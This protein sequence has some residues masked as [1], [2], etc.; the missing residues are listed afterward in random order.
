MK[1][2]VATRNNKKMKNSHNKKKSL[3]KFWGEK[4]KKK[5][6]VKIWK[7]L[8]NLQGGGIELLTFA[9]MGEGGVK[10][11]QNRAYVI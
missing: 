5:R 10:N 9:Y 8:R 3:G 11:G 1:T 2:F 4:N 6:G 7:C